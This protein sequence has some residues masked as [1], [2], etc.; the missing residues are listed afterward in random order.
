MLLGF[1]IGSF[2][3]PMLTPAHVLSKK[4]NVF[5]VNPVKLS[6][7]PFGSAPIALYTVNVIAL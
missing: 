5:C 1:C 4:I 6:K 7:V 2:G 3:E